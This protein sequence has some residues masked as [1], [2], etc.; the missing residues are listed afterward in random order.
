MSK[1]LGNI[2]DPLKLIESFGINS[3][4]LYFLSNGPQQGDIDFN[5]N[6]IEEFYYKNIANGLSIIYLMLS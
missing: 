1:S 4:R 3:V 2:V 6:K 5:D